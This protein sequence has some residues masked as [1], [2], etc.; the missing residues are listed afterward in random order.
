M[1]GL[2]C[3]TAVATSVAGR[4]RRR[5]HRRY[6]LRVFCVLRVLY[7]LHDLLLWTWQ[8]AGDAVCSA[9]GSSCCMARWGGCAGCAGCAAGSCSASLPAVAV[10]VVARALVRSWCSKASNSVCYPSH[11]RTHLLHR[12]GCL[13]V[14]LPF[15][16]VEH[17][18]CL[19]HLTTDV[20]PRV[21][22]YRAA[23]RP[24]V[25]SLQR[26]STHGRDGPS[27]GPSERRRAGQGPRRYSARSRVP[28]CEPHPLGKLVG[29]QRWTL[30][31]QILSRCPHRR[32]MTR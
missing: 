18:E 2:P 24:Q 3:G 17:S 27:L 7:V 23:D 20:G 26:S 12:E 29:Q 21:R 9:A 10:A 11:P 8:M 32:G 16:L 30:L 4:L 31:P 15:P 19:R 14:T 6:V 22:P 5:A 25:N 28:A 1:S 13:R